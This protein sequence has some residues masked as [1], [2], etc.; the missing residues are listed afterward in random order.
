MPDYSEK[1]HQYLAE[2]VKIRGKI[3]EI[4]KKLDIPK[5]WLY[6]VAQGKIPNPQA[7]RVMKIINF[8]KA[9]ANG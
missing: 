7:N 9:S 4:A 1:A 8:K 3:P 6:K 2:Q 5:A